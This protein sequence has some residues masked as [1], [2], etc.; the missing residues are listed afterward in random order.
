MRRMSAALLDAAPRRTR[1][2]GIDALR[3]GTIF[4]VVLHHTSITYGAIGGWYYK[5]VPTDGSLTSM[6][7]VFFCT[8]NQAWFMGLFF[9]LAGYYTPASLRTKGSWYYLRD[10]LQRL[11]IPLLAYGFVIGPA[12]IS[13]AQT[14]RGKPFLDTLLR[15]WGHGEFEK[16]PM[17]FAWALLIFALGA[18]LWRA[19]G[20]RRAESDAGRAFPTDAA[21]LVAALAT[22]AVAFALRL[23]WPVGKEGWGLQLGYF[24]SY[25]TL[26]VAGCLAASPRWLERLPDAQVRTWRRVAWIALPVLPVVAVLGG[27][28]LG[29]QGRPEGGWNIPALVYALWE[30]FVAWGVILALLQRCERRFRELGPVGTRLARRAF[31][32]YVIHPPVVVAVTLAWRGVAAP[33]LLKFA[34]SGSVACVLCYLLAGQLLHVPGVK[35]VL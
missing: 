27:S 7:L 8:F 25:V 6:L 35:R 33:A 18:V 9:L 12:T 16:G 10:R 5:E 28:L 30:P 26:F 1:N 22:G 29:I 17:W 32:I 20:T 14:A 34:L 31:A 24:A 15:L 21:L 23:Q 2:A 13:L 3:V 19:L 4:L 11:G